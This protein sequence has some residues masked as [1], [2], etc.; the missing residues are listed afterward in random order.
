[1]M[2]ELNRR[3]QLALMIGGAV[4]LVTLV[5]LGIVTPY[6]NSLDAMDKRIMSRQKQAAALEEQ[7]REYRTLKAVTSQIEQR[8][9]QSGDLSLISF[10]EATAARL[11]ASDRLVY[12]RP[13]PIKTADDM[14]KE[15]V[16]VKFERIRLDQLV[17]LLHEVETAAGL[18]Q[19]TQ[20]RIKTR[21]DDPSQ[22]DT[23]L[24]LISYGGGR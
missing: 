8:S 15:A 7:F 20:L 16:E 17:T 6:Q 22:L 3:E 14:V 13:Q 24:T 4:V 1:M 19:T 21:F 9:Q 2:R 12:L 10:V 23:V 18:L 11:S 5:V